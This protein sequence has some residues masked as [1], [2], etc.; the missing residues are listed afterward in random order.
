MRD[1]FIEDYLTSHK[2]HLLKEDHQT[3]D[4]DLY[5][6]IEKENEKDIIVYKTYK[7]SL[8]LEGHI[9]ENEIEQSIFIKIVQN[10][11]NKSIKNI[12]FI[13]K[14]YLVGFLFNKEKIFSHH[15][16]DIHHDRSFT[17]QYSFSHQ[18]IKI[19]GN[20]SLL[21]LHTNGKIQLT[22][23]NLL[24][25]N[26]LYS[27]LG[28]KLFCPH[29]KFYS[30]TFLRKILVSYILSS[31]NI[32]HYSTEKS[33]LTG[34]LLEIEKQQKEIQN[35]HNNELR[36]QPSTI[37]ENSDLD[38]ELEDLDLSSSNEEKNEGEDEDDSSE[39]DYE[40]ENKKFW[41]S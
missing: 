34:E 15:L 14:K 33:E 25:K 19:A 30:Y 3:K 8:F 20:F 1:H 10:I 4:Y 27:L 37:M 21:D 12:D 17:V 40:A 39:Y 2:L 23:K 36:K 18:A 28:M 9:K 31:Q 24:Y 26:I 29:L 13:D 7:N 11:K 32:P 35:F 6:S 5:L 16:L 22:K 38:V 41:N